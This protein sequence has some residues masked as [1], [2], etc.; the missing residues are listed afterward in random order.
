MMSDQQKID[1]Y[2]FD[3]CQK[4]NKMFESRQEAQLLL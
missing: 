3:I 2:P 4:E 1:K